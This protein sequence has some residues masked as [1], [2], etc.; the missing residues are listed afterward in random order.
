MT[1]SEAAEKFRSMYGEY[2]DAEL[3]Q[4]RELGKDI[5]EKPTFRPEDT[6]V[7]KAMI[8][9]GLVAGMSDL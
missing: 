9:A 4:L 7:G 5:T 6:V 3:A 1:E 8:E 2:T